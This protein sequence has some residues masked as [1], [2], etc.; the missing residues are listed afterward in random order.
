MLAIALPVW[1][2]HW[3]SAQRLLLGPRGG[4]EARSTTRR[5][6]LYLAAFASVV[7]V[8]I[9]G[10]WLVYDLTT[11]ALGRTLDRGLQAEVGRL[12]VTGAV[13]GAALWYHWWLVLRADLAAL[14]HATPGRTAVAIIAGLDQAQAE[15]L[16]E[17]V[18]EHLDG[19]R[20][21]L[22]WT[23]EAGAREAVARVGQAVTA[24]GCLP[25]SSMTTDSKTSAARR[26]SASE[27]P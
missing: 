13:A 27:M 26:T 22:V 6:Y 16:G 21:K 9:V 15:R 11:V 1:W 17:L 8:L 12:L 20:V 10:A 14:R 7:A 4:E 23:D 3:R 19:S 24:T 25:A 2:Y 18:R 5:W